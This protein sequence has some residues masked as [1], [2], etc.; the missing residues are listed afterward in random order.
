MKAKIGV[1]KVSKARDM[2]FNTR[3]AYGTGLIS[4]G[5]VETDDVP[6]MATDGKRIFY[7]PKW[8]ADKTLDNIMFVIMHEILHK[9]GAH[10]YRMSK[11]N[12]DDHEIANIAADLAINCVL[13]NQENRIPD[14]IDILLPGYGDYADMPRDMSFEWY[15]D[16]L[17]KDRDEQNQ[18]QNDSDKADESQDGDEEGGNSGGQDGDPDEQDGNSDGQSGSSDENGDKKGD[19]SHPFAGGDVIPSD[20]VD[21]QDIVKEM[22]ASIATSPTNTYG[23]T[24]ADKA[25]DAIRKMLDEVINPP[26]VDYKKLLKRYMTEQ[27][28]KRKRSFARPSRYRGQFILPGY[29]KDKTICK[30]AVI[31]DTSGSMDSRTIETAN[32]IYAIAEQ[33]MQKVVIYM[34]DDKLRAI[35]PINSQSDIDKVKQMGFVG[36]Y[37]TDMRPAFKQA[38]LDGCKL[39]INITD[40]CFY[41]Y[42]EN[43]RIP[44]IWV[45]IAGYR[46]QGDVPYGVHIKVE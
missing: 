4:M 14:D 42:P 11:M 46:R 38:V 24:P 15:Y 20:E 1:D 35:V 21:I 43:P 3:R 39:I 40:M 29:I 6:A 8:C 22:S 12:V 17:K 41:N 45:D 2:V 9:W 18:Q 19:G 44:V 33:Y 37:G 7:N 13:V 30:T 34:C 23:R 25:Y 27:M 5:M 32:E 31:I 16:K 36:G 10:P 28:A 26:K